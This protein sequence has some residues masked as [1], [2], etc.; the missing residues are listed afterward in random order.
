MTGRGGWTDL[1]QSVPFDYAGDALLEFWVKTKKVFLGLDVVW[2][3]KT[4]I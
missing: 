3:V 4:E 1:M 2:G